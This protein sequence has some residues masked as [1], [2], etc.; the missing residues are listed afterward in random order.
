[1]SDDEP[2]NYLN[3]LEDHHSRMRSEFEERNKRAYANPVPSALRMQAPIAGS[4]SR[5]SQPKSQL[6]MMPSNIEV[7]LED[8]AQ[9]IPKQAYD[10]GRASA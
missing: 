8:S 1:M 3:V 7:D 10:Y 2:P 4:S 9:G 6:R 5:L